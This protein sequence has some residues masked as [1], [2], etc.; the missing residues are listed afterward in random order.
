MTCKQEHVTLSEFEV[1]DV[2]IDR[3]Y[4]ETNSYCDTYAVQ[5][6]VL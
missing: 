5:S 6:R 1:V 2:D 3:L 4:G